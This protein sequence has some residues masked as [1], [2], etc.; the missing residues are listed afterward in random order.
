MKKVA[1]NTEQKRKGHK[2]NYTA[3]GLQLTVAG[4][5]IA[6]IHDQP[7]RFLEKLFYADLKDDGIMQTDDQ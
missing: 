1:P 2:T 3:Y 4:Q 6:Y 7:M 5:Q